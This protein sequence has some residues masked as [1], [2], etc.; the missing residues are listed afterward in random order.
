M[1]FHSNELYP[2][3]SPYNKSWNDVE[4]FLQKIMKYIVWLEENYEVKFNYLS[5]IEVEA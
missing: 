3:A 4:L 2:E 5:E 1:M